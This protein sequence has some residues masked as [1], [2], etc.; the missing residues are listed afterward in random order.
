T[1]TAQPHIRGAFL[2]INSS[3]QQFGTSIASLIGG[4]IVIQSADHKLHNYSILGYIA[5]FFSIL[6]V[7][8]FN[9]VKPLKV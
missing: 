2:I 4:F 8:V 1:S 5:V 9:K 3:V 7:L 6:V